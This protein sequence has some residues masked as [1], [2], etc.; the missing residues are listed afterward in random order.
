MNDA[1]TE[2]V[3][4]QGEGSERG[5]TGAFYE[6][7]EHHCPLERSVRMEMFFNCTVQYGS[8]QP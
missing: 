8:Q 2:I 7:L 1:N 6:G 4:V 3:P 5:S